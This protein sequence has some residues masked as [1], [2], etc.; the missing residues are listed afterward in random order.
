MMWKPAVHFRGVCG[1]PSSLS[2]FFKTAGD[3]RTVRE[4]EPQGRLYFNLSWSSHL[5]Q[6]SYPPTHYIRKVPQ[7][8][9][10]YFTFLQ[11]MQLL[12]LCTFGMYPIPYMKMIFP[13][14][15]ILLI[16]IRYD[17]GNFLSG[18]IIFLSRG[19]KAGWHSAEAQVTKGP[20]LTWICLGMKNLFQPQSEPPISLTAPVTGNK[21]DGSGFIIS[22]FISVMSFVFQLETSGSRVEI[23]MFCAAVHR[24][25]LIKENVWKQRLRIEQQMGAVHYIWYL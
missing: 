22:Y 7:R 11:M 14:L 12:V 4:K 23:Q 2:H 10:H 3:S 8:K 16:P 5:L 17:C 20:R 6:T 24:C 9:I 18:Q 25:S 13:L 1:P 21:T 15:M 19:F